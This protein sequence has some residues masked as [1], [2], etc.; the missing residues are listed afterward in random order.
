[1]LVRNIPNRC[2]SFVSP[3]IGC[4]QRNPRTGLFTL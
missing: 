4:R 2:I 3:Y 1:L